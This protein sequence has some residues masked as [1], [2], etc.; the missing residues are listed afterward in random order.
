MW[1]IRLLTGPQAGQIIDLK[2]GKNV[3][4]RGMTCDI[5]LI[6]QGVSKEHSEIHVYKEKIVMMDLKSSNGTYINGVRI[7][8]GLIRLG[9]KVSVHDVIFDVIPAETHK[10][11]AS[12]HI[13]MP[14]RE[15]NAAVA[16]QY[17]QNQFPQD[18]PQ[19]APHMMGHIDPVLPTPGPVAV[20]APEGLFQNL[21]FQVQ[22]YMER[23]A[24]P[25][26]YRLPQLTEFRYV[27]AGFIG[28]FIV[29][30]TLLSMIP[31]VQIT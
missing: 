3:I 29:A 25:G 18:F 11:Q 15:G 6:S 19:Q 20:T 5:K 30:V 8:N 26:V 24:L 22:E 14:S 10:T 12:I 13:A 2:M 31:M 23:V 21:L 17:Q 4:G 27:L 9:D 7:Q 28:V 1:A 16:M